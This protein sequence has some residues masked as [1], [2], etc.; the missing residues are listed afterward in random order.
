MALP[1]LLA[2]TRLT[3]SFLFGVTPREPLVLVGSVVV[4]GVAT[5]VA[6][7]LP[8]RRAARMDPMQ[9]LRQD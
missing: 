4:L 3:E 7:Y 5:L 9:A 2:T 8:A 1:P 6:G